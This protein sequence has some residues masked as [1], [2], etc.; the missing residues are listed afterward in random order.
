[1]FSAVQNPA[2]NM[3]DTEVLNRPAVNVQLPASAFDN[4][5]SL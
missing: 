5:L 3:S 4:E 2:Q 1:M